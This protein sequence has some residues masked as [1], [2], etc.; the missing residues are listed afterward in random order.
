MA[1]APLVLVASDLG[2]RSDRVVERGLAMAGATGCGV[3]LVHVLDGAAAA[4]P[5]RLERL[6]AMARRDLGE[7]ADKVEIR[8]EQGSVPATLARVA[9]DVDAPVIVI[10]TARFNSPVDFVLGTAVDYLVRRSPVPV[11]VVR[12]R[13]SRPYERLLVLTDFSNTAHSAL[14]AAG[15]F[16]AGAEIELLHVYGA[17]HPHRLDAEASAAQV[18]A[19]AEDE[20][21]LLLAE[22]EASLRGRITARVEEGDLEQAVEER[23]LRGAFDLLVLGT[24]GRGRVAHATIGSRASALLSASL[25]DV[26]M[27]RNH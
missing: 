16:F 11:L 15:D 1:E 14:E 5:A 22:V 12:R 3:L 21:E 13:S 23:F 10:G 25:S 17:A 27:V 4:D 6:Q 2:A 8:L 20:M 24:H 7:R 19:E 9:L 26:M 18:R